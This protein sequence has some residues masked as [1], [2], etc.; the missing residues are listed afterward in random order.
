MA[1][2]FRLLIGRDVGVH[3][4]QLPVLHR[5]IAFRDIGGIDALAF[6]FRSLKDHPALNIVINRIVEPRLPVLGDDLVVRIVLWLGHGCGSRWCKVVYI[7]ALG[8]REKR[9]TGGGVRELTRF[10]CVARA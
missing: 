10:A 6:D 3:E 4:P 5:R 7:G 8:S 9:Q 2:C 1:E